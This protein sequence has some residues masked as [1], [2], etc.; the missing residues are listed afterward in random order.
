MPPYRREI[1][2]NSNGVDSNRIST[3]AKDDMDLGETQRQA[4]V[5]DELGIET[6]ILDDGW[7][8][9]SGDWCPD[10]PDCREAP[11]PSVDPKHPGVPAPP[12]TAPMFPPRFPDSSFSAVR[13][14][15]AQ[16]GGMNL[17]LWMT[18]QHFHPSAL[19]F[20]NNPQWACMPIDA[21]LLAQ[22]QADP[23]GGSQEAGIMQWNLEG[24]GP[25]GKAVDY[26][27]SR[28]RR[29]IDQWGVKY[30]KF[31]FTVWVDCGGSSATD[32]Y[33]TRESFMA[34]LD[35][36]LADHP[37]VTIQMD[38]TNDY[39]LFPFEALA[40]GPTW[41][42]NSSPNTS[43]ALHTN[44]VLVPFLPP[45]ALGR[46][47]LNTNRLST[48]SAG[49]QM[50]VALLSHVTF[51][52]DLPS[53]PASVRATVRRW[54]D[55]YK[56]HREDLATFT[57]PLLTEDP[58]SAANWAAFQAW[59]PETARG[60]LLV[61]RQDSDAGSKTIHLR[62]VPAGTYRLYEAPDETA[63]ADYTAEQLR[64]GIDISLPAK[65]SAK[66]LRIERIGS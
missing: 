54:N 56:A 51:F 3:G 35:R 19:A 61:Y 39:R 36:I 52:N 15:L 21:A 59:N 43:E 26:I 23:N 18:P 42:Q 57:Y 8:A 17:G 9:R 25:N 62:N 10:S 55:Y 37:D 30:F 66:V 14:V 47:A 29:A 20:Q 50:A 27:E 60:T 49:Y 4:A 65:R 31:D 6:F 13:G 12:A 46:N 41:Y 16:N 38:E 63:S 7:Q 24:A 2:F 34:M 48:D 11:R 28:I 1:T 53:I 44:Q 40:R 58:L 33:G 32:M 64:A 45:Y 22:Q 5:A